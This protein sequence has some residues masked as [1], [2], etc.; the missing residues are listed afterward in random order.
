MSVFAAITVARFPATFIERMTKPSFPIVPSPAP[1][2]RAAIAEDRAG[3]PATSAPSRVTASTSGTSTPS[4][5]RRPRAI[6]SRAARRVGD[7]VPITTSVMAARPPFA[8]A[9]PA[10]GRYRSHSS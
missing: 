9:V 2:S 10:R 3:V 7:P 8:P 6:S 5:P 1:T 4:I